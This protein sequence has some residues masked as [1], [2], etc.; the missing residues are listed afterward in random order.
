MKKRQS[1]L[2]FHNHPLPN[3]FAYT[4]LNDFGVENQYKIKI[5]TSK[6]KSHTKPLGLLMNPP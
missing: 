6:Q 5:K 4:E 2:L 3:L 1:S